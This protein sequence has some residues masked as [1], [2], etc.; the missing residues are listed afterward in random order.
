MSK[1]IDAEPSTYKEVASLHVWN[2]ATI[3]EY[4]SIMKN[5][6]WEVVPRPTGKSVVTFRWIY[7][8]KYVVDGSIERIKP[9]L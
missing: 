6:V 7:K 8:I 1:L 3:E 2:D 5:D 9:N 4:N